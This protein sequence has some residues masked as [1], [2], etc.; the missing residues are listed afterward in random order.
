MPTI[1][2]EPATPDRFGDLEHALSGGGDGASCQC[3]WWMLPNK[4]W[5]KTTRGE[6]EGMLRAELDAAPP[7][8][9]I[10]YADG[11]PAGW[12]RV[13]PRPTQVRLGR[14]R[15]F[16]ANSPEPWDDPSVWA[17]SCFVVRREHRRTGLNAQLLAAAVEFAR[18]NGARVIEAYPTDT[19]VA[20]KSSNDLYVGVLSVFEDAGFHEVARP[21]PERTIVELD[22]TAG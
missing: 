14:T 5:E 7:P 17:V 13:G 1:T 18:R 11:E 22:L 6:R 21:R 3:Q 2:I 19:N 16:N 20:K 15:A 10:A 9:L 4:D 12:I 8:G